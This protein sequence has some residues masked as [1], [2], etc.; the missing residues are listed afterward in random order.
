MV[1]AE[2]G[3]EILDRT[4]FC[5]V[6]GAAAGHAIG[7]PINRNRKNMLYYS[8]IGLLV[9]SVIQVISFNPL[10][11]SDFSIWNHYAYMRG[12][13]WFICDALPFAMVSCDLLIIVIGIAGFLFA[14]RQKT[15]VFS[16]TSGFII[17][18]ASAG[19]L[20]MR[21]VHGH[22]AFRSVGLGNYEV[23]P[24]ETIAGIQ[25]Q[26]LRSLYTLFI[27][28]AIAAILSFCY[29]Y[30]SFRFRKPSS[31]NV[32]KVIV[33]FGFLGLAG[34]FIGIFQGGNVG[35]GIPPVAIW[36]AVAFGVML[37]VGIIGL[38][39]SRNPSLH[40]MWGFAQLAIFT[41]CMLQAIYYAYS[42]MVQGTF[43]HN[44][45]FVW[46]TVL[47][48]ILAISAPLSAFYTYS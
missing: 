4:K 36:V 25:E 8:S 20:V 5:P 33:I 42:A 31:L 9:L 41:F 11:A 48:A 34:G 29:V 7:S 12:I 23:M 24:P 1:C 43:F 44:G 40:A 27:F 30:F 13:P 15:A 14:K 3:Q 6:C 18:I 32:S 19:L 28:T 26:Y 21:I 17:S 10:I 38:S 45:P 2:C 37:F 16:K 47:S 46:I 22:V 35:K 39:G